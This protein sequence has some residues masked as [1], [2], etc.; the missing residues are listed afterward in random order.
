[1]IA[2]NKYPITKSR[3]KILDKSGNIG[4]KSRRCGYPGRD[5]DEQC[6]SRDR[7]ISA[8]VELWDP[9]G[10]HQTRHPRRPA[11]RARIRLGCRVAVSA[12]SVVESSGPRATQPGCAI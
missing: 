1:M 3:P 2:G 8:A 5:A 10:S 11:A 6:R 12:A 7:I 9:P 4:D